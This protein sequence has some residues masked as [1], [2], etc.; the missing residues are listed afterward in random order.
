MITLISLLSAIAIMQAYRLGQRAGRKEFR[1][2]SWLVSP[3]R[4]SARKV[5]GELLLMIESGAA[6]LVIVLDAQDCEVVWAAM[7]DDA[8]EETAGV[9]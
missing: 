4:L 7:W 6:D 3:S 2:H 5:D 9:E 8:M 1:E